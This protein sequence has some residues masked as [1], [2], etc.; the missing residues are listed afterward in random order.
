MH[1]RET[2]DVKSVNLA[3]HVSVDVITSE[4]TLENSP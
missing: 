3:R 4:W 1:E 2:L